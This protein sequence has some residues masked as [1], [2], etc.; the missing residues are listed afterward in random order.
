MGITVRRQTSDRL[1]PSRAAAE[2][3]ARSSFRCGPE[4]QHR[5]R[6]LRSI[7]H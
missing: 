6:F 4:C 1:M 7:A 5:T 2:S 3:T